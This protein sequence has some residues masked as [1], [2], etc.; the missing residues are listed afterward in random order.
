ML[1]ITFQF[2]LFQASSLQFWFDLLLSEFFEAIL[3]NL[4]KPVSVQYY[5]P[6]M[7]LFPSMQHVNEEC[8]SSKKNLQCNIQFNIGAP[9]VGSNTFSEVETN[10]VC[11]QVWIWYETRHGFWVQVSDH[12]EEVTTCLAHEIHQ[13]SGPHMQECIKDIIE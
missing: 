3:S 8:P 12:L 6:C 7:K 2:S 13:D 9:L 10:E 11:K 4:V 5:L 1:Y